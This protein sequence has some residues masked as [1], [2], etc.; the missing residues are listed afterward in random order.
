MWG[1]E[2]VDL[3]IALLARNADNYT[4]RR[5]LEIA[6]KRAIDLTWYNP[7]RIAVGGSTLMH[8]GNELPDC[9]LY[10]L[11]TSVYVEERDYILSVAR[12]LEKRRGLLINAARSVEIASNKFRTFQELD[13]HSI[14]AVPSVTLRSR[15]SMEDA[16]GSLGGYPLMLKFFH[17][18]Q[19]TGVVYV[20]GYEMLS[21]LVDSY[22]ALGAN[23]FLQPYVKETG[24][25]TIR[26]LLVGDEVIKTVRMI[27]AKGDFRSNYKKGGTL[28]AES[29]DESLTSLAVSASKALGLI[30]AGVDVLETGIGPMVLEVNSS[31]GV[32]SIEQICGIDLASPVFDALL[33]AAGSGRRE[34][35]PAGRAS[36]LMAEHRN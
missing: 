12:C 27:P 29:V 8:Q 11:R 34:A 4:H 13:A 6:A 10:L 3:K 1:I 25:E 15:S 2:E 22:W 33:H 16:V 30:F 14:P 23:V 18:T 20:S 32:E 31:P 7:L 9:D 21:A 36:E 35:L 19:G 26:V 24:G 28:R 17:G 5:F